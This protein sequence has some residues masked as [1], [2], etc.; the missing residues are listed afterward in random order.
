METILFN[1]VGDVDGDLALERK[2]VLQV[3]I[4]RKRIPF[5]NKLD[6][7]DGLYSF[8]QPNLKDEEIQK[9][10]W[11]NVLF[12]TGE[13]SFTYYFIDASSK[14]YCPDM[15]PKGKKLRKENAQLAIEKIKKPNNE[16]QA[17]RYFS[18]AS[19]QGRIDMTLLWEDFIAYPERPGK[20]IDKKISD[21]LKKKYQAQNYLYQNTFLADSDLTYDNVEIDQVVYTI[22]RKEKNPEFYSYRNPHFF[23]YFIQYGP[24]LL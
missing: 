7:K 15:S 23:K 6:P 14:I 5:Y 10:G 11:L 9:E 2:D 8:L 22:L 21:E 19:M 4:N 13:F 20:L 17:T 1:E 16:F 18:R 3:V 12:K 24:K